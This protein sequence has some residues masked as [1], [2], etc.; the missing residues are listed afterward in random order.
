ML[1]VFRKAAPAAGAVPVSP[2]GL[3]VITG[4]DVQS[5]LAQLD[6]VAGA[7]SKGL[8]Q[9]VRL[10]ALNMAL[11]TAFADV[12]GASLA[13]T[14]DGRPIRF[15]W[16]FPISKYSVITGTQALQLQVVDA[17]GGAKN[18]QV[19]YQMRTRLFPNNANDVED[20]DA[21][22]AAMSAY[23]DGT[24]FAIGTTYTMKLQ[25]RHATTASDGNW[26]A[27]YAPN[28]AFYGHFSVY[29]D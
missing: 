11:T 8:I 16:R 23:A 21:E 25:A 14:Y 12:P 7:A 28:S 13:F 29:G 4:T 27:A 26:T 9:Q 3:L 20:I 24:A 22:T 1:Q 15:K 6:A 5:A 10:T 18:G 19:Q 17:S 2:S